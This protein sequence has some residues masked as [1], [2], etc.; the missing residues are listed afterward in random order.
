V[1]I[2]RELMSLT[3]DATTMVERVNKFD[4]WGQHFNMRSQTTAESRGN[5]KVG[6]AAMSFYESEFAAI[7]RQAAMISGRASEIRSQIENLLN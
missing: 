3:G 2:Q 1:D 4:A 7:S 6:L 5:L